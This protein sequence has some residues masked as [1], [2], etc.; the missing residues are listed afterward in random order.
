MKK[1]TSV[2]AGQEIN[3][4]AVEEMARSVLRVY[5][6]PFTAV[7][8]IALR[9]GWRVVVHDG[10]NLMLRAPIPA[11]PPISVRQAIIDAVET[12]W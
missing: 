8:I 7:A 12:V 11:G 6:V 4:A 5:G 10:T 9:S 1:Q 2:A 3:P